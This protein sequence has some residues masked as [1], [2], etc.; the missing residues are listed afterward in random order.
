MLIVVIVAFNV[1]WGKLAEGD[2]LQELV[3]GELGKFRSRSPNSEEESRKQ[4]AALVF[5]ET[6]SKSLRL[7]VCL[8][9]SEEGLTTL[10]HVSQ[11]GSALQPFTILPQDG[12]NIPSNSPAIGMG[13]TFTVVPPD[14]YVLSIRGSGIHIWHFTHLGIKS[15]AWEERSMPLKCDSIFSCFSSSTESKV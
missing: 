13:T 8:T 10:T 14:R 9:V 4:Q 3:G 7:Y 15:E 1:K 5:D 11:G 2:Q 6:Y 12:R